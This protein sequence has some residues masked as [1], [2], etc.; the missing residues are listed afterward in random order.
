MVGSFLW[1][2]PERRGVYAAQ[3]S[4]VS[5]P[6]FYFFGK[7]I[8]LGIYLPLAGLSVVRQAR[9]GVDTRRPPPRETAFVDQ[10]PVS[11]AMELEAVAVDDH[12]N[13]TSTTKATGKGKAKA[14]AE[15]TADGNANGTSASSSSDKQ[16]AEE[17]VAEKAP[18]PPMEVYHPVWSE[19]VWMY[20]DTVRG[21]EGGRGTER[22]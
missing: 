5:A 18:H 21:R 15:V 3:D 11:S 1:R 17:A 13:G 7:G 10:T 4:F 8:F 2:N 19:S 20:Y 16:Q 12:A 22:K 9:L 6:R 14:K